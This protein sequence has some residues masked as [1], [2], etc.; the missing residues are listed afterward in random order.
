M[1]PGLEED[2]K[3]ILSNVSIMELASLPKSMIVIGAG[4][5]G[6][7]FASIFKTFGTEVTV[8]EMLPRAVPNEDAD[9]SRELE[10]QFKKRKITLLTNAKYEGVKKSAKGVTVTYSRDGKKAD[11]SADVVLCAVGRKPR[12]EGIGLEKTKAKVERGYVHVNKWMETA[13]PGV[14]AIGDIVAGMPWLAHAA[15]WQGLSVVG[16]IAGKSVQPVR[17]D[18]IPMVTFCEPQIAS[19]GLSEAQ[20]KEQGYKVKVGKFPFGGNSKATIIGAHG[21]FI[22]LIAEEKHGEILGVHIIG[23]QATEMISEAT[24]ALQLEATVDDLKATV[25][26]HPTLWEAMAEA[27]NAVDGLTVNV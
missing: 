24:V 4:A 7:E 11:V 21:G 15:S 14:Y 27:A 26:A 12:T 3:Q 13:E 5:V 6:V 25:H 1:L 9:I 22:K 2:G 17:R 16:R 18:R 19:V 10:R 20:A 8:I 23:P